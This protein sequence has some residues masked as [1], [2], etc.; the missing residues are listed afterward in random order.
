TGYNI[1][2]VEATKKKGIVVTNV[3]DYGTNTVAQMTFALLLELTNHV[4]HHNQKVKE[5][6]WTQ[7][8]DWCFWE[9]S[10]VELSDKTIGILGYGRIGRKVAEIARA[11]GMKVIATVNNPTKRASE[12][13]VEFVNADT[14]FTQSDVISLHCPL[15]PETKGIINKDSIEK[16]KSNAIIINTARGPLIIEDDLAD[17]LGKGKIAGAAVDVASVE[18]IDAGNP[19][20]K[21]KNCIVTPHIAWATREA[22]IRLL[23]SAIENL[24]MFLKGSPINRV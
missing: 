1:V 18:P 5:G 15:T 7:S 16:M 14:L 6:K 3:P 23:N 8:L 11:F 2:D 4:G 13:N 21:A 9:K 10:L 19:L 17:A 12:D 20:L 24:E 22:R